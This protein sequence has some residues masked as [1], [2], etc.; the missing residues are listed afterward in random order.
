M[1][2]SS[3]P[4]SAN[5]PDPAVSISRTLLHKG[6][7]F[8]FELA[9]IERPGGKTL[10]REV[11]R[12]PGAVVVVPRLDNG[13][14]VLIRVRRWPLEGE[15]Q[16]ECCAGTIDRDDAGNPEP[17]DTCAARELIEETGYSAAT[18]TPL[19]W[20][21]TTPGMTDERMHAFFATG[22][23]HVGQALEEDEDIRVEVVDPARVWSMM[24]TGELRDA[25]SMLAIF[26]AARRGLL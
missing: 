21:Y 13:H 17:P 18:L 20:F 26:L 25:K 4:E 2:A 11:V 24:D 14:I 19:G 16:W 3:T 22:L 10:Q 9:R 15:W 5:C 1:P 23:H 12:H 8:D 6:R 7:K